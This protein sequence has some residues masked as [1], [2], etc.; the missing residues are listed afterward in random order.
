[1]PRASR[2]STRRTTSSA[3][4]RRSQEKARLERY[5]RQRYPDLGEL[6]VIH[7]Q[8]AGIDLGGRSSHFVAAP[9]GE[10]I[11]VRE[12]GMV[13]SQ[14]VEMAQYL[15]DLGVRTVAM[16]STGVYWMPVCDLL[17]ACG[18]EVYLVN[19]HHVKN[20]PGRKKSDKLDCRWLQKLHTYGLLSASFRPAREIRP[21]RSFLRHRT[22]VV[23]EA[24]D[25][26]RRM[27]RVLDMMNVRPHKALTDLG[28]VTGM[29]IVRALV[30]GEYDPAALARLRD[31]HCE[32]SEE[33]LREELTG[34]C[35]PHLVK[36]LASCLRCY[37]NLLAEIAVVDADIE[38]ELQRLAPQEREE[39]A[40]RLAEDTHARPNGKHAPAFNAAGYVEAVA[41]RD[42]TL[43]PG[44][45][46]QLALSLLAELGLDM[47]KW[48]TEKHFGAH[49]TLAP[50][51][52]ISG[53]R[54]LSCHTH[55]G[56]HPAAVLFRQ[57]A[58]AVVKM[59]DSAL[60]AFYRRLAV[61]VG[62]AKALTALAYKLA[63]MYYHLMKEGRQYVEVGVEAYEEKHQRQQV[64]LLHKRARKLGYTV[65]PIAT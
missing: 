16:E 24:A 51:P 25:W 29:R 61:R 22:T 26:L 63:R 59:S 14:L 4:T 38:E 7:P 54:V 60:A 33:E 10:E 39:L 65:Q 9:V 31:P 62:K 30:A 3:A 1:M 8:A 42:P 36:Q 53:G 13:T 23:R 18:L 56:T 2:P 50:Q 55:P 28:G 47:S 32:C 37:D 48:P 17:E 52:K 45:G 44:I 40:A 34:F 49:L 20:V 58:A 21:L 27:Q 57:A 43:I 41:N 64:A 15:C 5:F 35:Q 46:P 12:F 11:E 6:R 19:P